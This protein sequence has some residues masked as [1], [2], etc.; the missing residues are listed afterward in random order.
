MTM[1][2]L[3]A[4]AGGLLQVSAGEAALGSAHEY[5]VGIMEPSGYAELINL[6]LDGGGGGACC[7]AAA[8]LAVPAA[9]RNAST[10]SDCSFLIGLLF[11]PQIFPA[12]A[13]LYLEKINFVHS[14]R[15]FL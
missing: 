4:L 15:R 2:K 3:N 10:V 8:M 12:G 7:C 9:N 6:N 5:C 1:A 11:H 13:L 14:P